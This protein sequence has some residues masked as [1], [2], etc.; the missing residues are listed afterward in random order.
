MKTLNL[1]TWIGLFLLVLLVG[2][3]AAGPIQTAVAL[4]AYVFC[5]PT[6]NWQYEMYWSSPGPILIERVLFYA[7]AFGPPTVP[8][9]GH[10]VAWA[11]ASGNPYLGYWSPPQYWGPGQTMLE[12]GGAPVNGLIRIIYGCTG[13]SLQGTTLMMILYYRNEP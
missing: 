8:F 11:A 6:T 12:I 4:D 5:H 3:V 13:P 10:I 7:E 1:H 9:S 2:P